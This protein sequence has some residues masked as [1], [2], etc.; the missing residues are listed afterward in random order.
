MFHCFGCGK[1]GD[2]ISFLRDYEGMSFYEAL[3]MLADR[4]GVRLP[5]LKEGGSKEEYQRA[6]LL[7][8]GKSAA[9]F[10]RQQLNDP[11]KGGV[12]KQYLKTRNLQ[13]ATVERFGLGFAP[14]SWD[15]LPDALS[16]A[17]F[18]DALSEQAGLIRRNERG[19][20]YAFFRNRL[21]VPIR[22]ATGHY[23]AFGGRDLSGD[24]HGPKYINTPETSVYKKNR[25][26]YGLHEARDAMRREKRVLLVEGYF[27]LM[28]CFDSG[29]ENVVAPCG[30]ALTDAQA[31]LLRR[32]VNEVVVVFDGDA[33][34]VRAALRSVGILTA[35]GLTVKALLLPE[36]QDPDDFIQAQGVDAFRDAVQNAL[37]FVAF[38]ARMSADRLE[39]IEGR[40]DVARELFTI[41]ME[42]DDDLRRDEYLKV[43]AGELKLDVW[44]LRREFAKLAAENRRRRP[45]REAAEESAP[46]TRIIQ[47]DCDFV[48]ALLHSESL[49][50]ETR[51]ALEGLKLRPSPVSVVLRELL[52]EAGPALAQR[53]EDEQALQLY[54]AAVN[55]SELEQEKAET[56]VMKRLCRLKRDALESERQRVQEALRDAERRQDTEKVLEL[57]TQRLGLE[58]QIQKL[59][60]A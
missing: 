4:A 9:K 45:E 6:K 3:R 8:L 1:S 31:K 7:E 59:G 21:M 37:D 24:G 44:T 48:A 13:P 49:R 54:A 18:A 39:T 12:A 20:K 32:Y 43:A 34:G 40:T 14:D 58:R 36:G 41:L 22:D 28:R 25:V 55:R 5:A 29:I 50:K 23:V 42:V 17:G 52:V 38:Y 46:K 27:D 30:T 51:Q 11:L 10:F 33:A 60:A 26:L 57:V 19:G 47:D 56:V 15:A 53:I 2:T 16:K 35:A